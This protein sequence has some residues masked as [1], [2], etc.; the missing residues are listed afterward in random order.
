MI[1]VKLPLQ[2]MSEFEREWRESN[3]CHQLKRPP[4]WWEWLWEIMLIELF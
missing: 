3:K 4:K 1:H 2:P